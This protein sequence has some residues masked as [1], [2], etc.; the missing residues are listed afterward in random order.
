MATWAKQPL[1]LVNE[2]ANSTSDLLKFKQKIIDAVQAK[3][4][5]TLEQEPELI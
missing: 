5:I 2:H 1:V 3:F 4:G